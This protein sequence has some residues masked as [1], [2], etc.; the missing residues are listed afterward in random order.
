MSSFFSHSLV[1][2][3]VIVLSTEEKGA[4]VRVSKSNVATVLLSV[5]GK[6]IFVPV[7]D[8]KTNRGRPLKLVNGLIRSDVDELIVSSADFRVA[9]IGE[10][11]SRQTDDE[12][13]VAHTKYDN[14]N[15][16]RVDDAKK[17]SMLAMKLAATW[18][19]EDHVMAIEC[20]MPYSGTQLWDLAA[21][22]LTEYSQ[23]DATND[24][25][26]LVFAPL[27]APLASHAT[28]EVSEADA[29]IFSIL[30]DAGIVPTLMEN[31]A[32]A[33]ELASIQANI[34]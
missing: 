2:R 23:P 31:D 27:L 13:E 19:P 7:S 26:P 28:S 34:A 10:L 1:A 6:T 12:R 5:T 22:F 17:G 33:L 30:S 15:G 25:E 21:S 4:V 29:A 32:F 14:D 24:D 20:L 3:Q 9:A 18:M 16:F 8:L 11:F